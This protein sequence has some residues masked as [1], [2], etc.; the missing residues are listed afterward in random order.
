MERKIRI[1]ETD[2]EIFPFGLGTTG[3]GLAWD[4]EDADRIFDAFLDQG[5]SLIDTAHVYSD[6]VKPERARSE[7]VI[8]DWLSR[9]GKRNRAVIVT[10]GGHPD[11][12]VEN[13][14]THAS[15]MTKADMISDL[16]GSLRQLR[17]DYI[18]IYQM[19]WPDPNVPLEETAEALIRLKEQGKIRYVGLSNFAQEDVNKMMTMVSVDC[20]QSLYNMLERNTTSYHGIPLPYR[21]EDE[22]LPNVKKNGQAFLPYSPL[23]QGLLAGRFLDGQKF[24]ARDIRNENPK[25]SGEQ[26]EAYAACA[27]QLRILAEEMGRPLNELALNWLRQKPEVTSIIGGASSYAQLEKNVHCTTWEITD[28]QMQ[29][30]EEIIHPFAHR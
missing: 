26:F 21:T 18:D 1:P 4:G 15:R 9:S 20:Q 7:R 16:E 3:A 2:I 13:P 25:L 14:D 28:E 23:F 10:K 5:G 27:R 29:R 19:H 8:G 6:W 22:V 24:S 12:T 11:M 30:I 17:T